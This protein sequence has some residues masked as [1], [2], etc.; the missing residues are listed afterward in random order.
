[1][2][3]LAL[4]VA[5]MWA[6]ASAAEAQT[7]PPTPFDA[8]LT[9]YAYPYPVQML[10]VEAQQQPL[11]MA[12]MDVPAVRPSG[13]AVLLLHG[14]NFSAAYWAP[15]IR[16]LTAEG[17]R[18]IAPDQIGF[19]KSSKP[20]RFEYTF[21]QLAVLT[22][23]LLDRLGVSKVAVVGH[24]MGG[25]LA[26]R[27]AL[28]YPDVVERLCLVNPIGLED[29]KRGVPYK[30][31][32]ENLRTELAGTPE[33]VRAYMRDNYFAGQWKPEYEPLVE[34]P[35]GWMAGP[36]RARIAL[37]S[38]LTTDMV[39]T[40]PVVYELPDLKVPTLLVIGQRDR[41]AIGKAWAPP[42][43]KARLGNYPEL[44]RRA[45]AAIPGAQLVEIAEA[46][47]LP[48]VEQFEAYVR[49]LTSFLAGP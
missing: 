49:A 23:T 22:R 43:V 41:T 40:Q 29:W 7:A 2:P 33:S 38:A 37:T 9:Q 42:A 28:Q 31:I 47:H 4:V 21:Q 44:G 5:M 39:F 1:M 30:T 11:E 8:R 16:A 14:K 3:R 19:G 18:V 45:R 24:S 6:A 20:E 34:I 15:T 46:G 17:Y 12:Y 27:F 13:R 25:M 10:A 36:D 26:V 35:L 48:Q 32:D